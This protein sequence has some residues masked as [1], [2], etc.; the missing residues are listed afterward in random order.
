MSIIEVEYVDL[1]GVAGEDSGDLLGDAAVRARRDPAF[2]ARCEALLLDD[3]WGRWGF[4]LL[5]LMSARFGQHRT[6]RW[7]GGEVLEELTRRRTA[8]ALGPLGAPGPRRTP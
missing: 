5:G 8:R 1:T 7:D 4:A 3:R 2:R 6:P